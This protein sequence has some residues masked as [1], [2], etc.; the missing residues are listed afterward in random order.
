MTTDSRAQI[1]RIAHVLNA[2]DADLGFLEGIDA[3]SLRTLH[4]QMVDV[5]FD[6]SGSNLGSLQAAAK[7]LPPAITAKIAEKALG[8]V[9]CGRIAGSVDPALAVSISKRLP[10]SFLADVAGHVHPNQIES[11]ISQLPLE[12]V[13]AAA[14]VLVERADVVAL[15]HFSSIVSDSTLNKVIRSLGSAG[16]LDVAPFI[17]PV[18][19]TTHLIGLIDN[20]GLLGIVERGDRDGR[21]GD[22]FDL[23]D[24]LDA[25]TRKRIANLVVPR[26][27]LIDAALRAA[28]ELDQW[29]SLLAFASQAS[30]VPAQAWSDVAGFKDKKLVASAVDAAERHDLWDQLSTVVSLWPAELRKSVAKHV[31]AK[32][33]ARIGL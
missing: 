27:Q 2:D 18:E 28:V 8:P 21:W 23:V 22:A 10:T 33:R 20:T 31:K 29:S 5:L 32:N 25:P 13:D 11:I 14:A 26:P 17:E 24:R 4:N 9:L 1:I 7:I 19:R 30:D 16:L 15:G 12:Q 6:T 3:A